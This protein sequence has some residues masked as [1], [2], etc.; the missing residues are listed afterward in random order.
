MPGFPGC[1]EDESKIR[2][3]I[4]PHQVM[5]RNNL[6]TYFGTH[7]VSRAPSLYSQL[8]LAED[9]IIVEGD[10]DASL[11]PYH[12]H[13]RGLRREYGRS[14][15]PTINWNRPGE[16]VD[17]TR[18]TLETVYRG[19]SRQVH[20]TVYVDP[21]SLNLLQVLSYHHVANQDLRRFHLREGEGKRKIGC[22]GFW[23]F[24][25]LTKS[26]VNMDVNTRTVGWTEVFVPGFLLPY[27]AC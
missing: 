7:G 10:E 23:R 18:L 16:V 21:V 9:M 25:I 27:T 8:V 14:R 24:Q 26:L 1:P 17:E 2:Q 20:Q 12:Q 15:N 22:R 5:S 6:Q 19:L 13:L 3:L 4:T 11:R